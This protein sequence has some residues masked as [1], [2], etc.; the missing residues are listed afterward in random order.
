MVFGLIT[1]GPTDQ[2]VL[3]HLLARYFSNPD[4]DVR[5]V[6]PNTDSTDKADHFG[7]W[8]NVLQFCK[9]ADMKTEL[10]AKDYVV[11][12][13]DTDICEEYGVQKREGGV[14]LTGEEIA[15]KTREIIIASIG[16]DLYEEFKEK[17]VFAISYESIE[18]WLLPIYFNDNSRNKTLNCC[19]KLNQELSKGSFTIAYSGKKRPNDYEKICRNVKNKEKVEEISVHN[20]SFAQFIQ[21]LSA[22]PT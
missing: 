6:Q 19:E 18:C 16:A 13:I 9:S 12:Q 3:R 15:Q 22:I 1:E 11:I 10:E 4:I 17:I 7:G 14:D 2:V 21:S 8:F 20:S 5:P